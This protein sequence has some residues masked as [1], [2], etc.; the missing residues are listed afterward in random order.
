[1]LEIEL[2]RPGEELYHRASNFAKQAYEKRL[3]SATAAT[4]DLFACARQNDDVIGCLGLYRAGT[5][6]RFFFE[7]CHPE[8]AIERLVGAM[9]YRKEEVGELGTRAVRIP[10][11][12]TFKSADISAALIGTLALAAS[13]SGVRYLGFVTNRMTKHIIESLGFTF[14]TLGRFDVSAEDDAFRDNLKAFIAVPQW[15]AGFRLVS[16]A[17]CERALARL[18]SRG[19]RFPGSK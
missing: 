19:M 9:H 13:R 7:R 8:G 10:S 1:M 11:D 5:R 16:L 15:C 17:H 12:C 6:R 4:P 2:V 18:A 3:R 14:I